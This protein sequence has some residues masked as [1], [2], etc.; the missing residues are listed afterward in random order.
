M[1]V[2]LFSDDLLD[3][4]SVRGVHIVYIKFIEIIFPY[5]VSRSNHFSAIQNY[6]LV[7]ENY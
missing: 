3:G 5:I 7:H 6:Q 4:L 1:N 2:S